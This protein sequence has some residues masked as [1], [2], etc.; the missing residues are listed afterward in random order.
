MSITSE[1]IIAVGKFLKPYLREN[2]SDLDLTR[3]SHDVIVTVRSF[4][5]DAKVTDQALKP[6]DGFDAALD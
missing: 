4:D 1:E 3:C 6:D 2:I 5:A